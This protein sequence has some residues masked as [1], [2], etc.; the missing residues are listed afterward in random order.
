VDGYTTT[1]RLPYAQPTSRLGNYIRNSVKAAVDA[2]D[3]SIVLYV[4]DPKDPLIQAYQRIFPTLLK[5]LAQMPSDLRSHVRYPQDLF[6]I[7]AHVFAT[8]HMESPRVFYNKEDLW[9]IPKKGEKDMEPYYTI[10]KLPKT[11]GATEAPKEEFILLIP[12]T[13]AKRDNMAAWLAA[14][15]D[16]SHYG[17][18]IVYLF[19]K[20]KLVYGPR[21]VDARIDQDSAISQ[22]IT[23]WSQRGSQVI[24]G[25]LLAIPI[26]DALLYIQPLYLSASEGALPE[27]RRVIVA[28]GNHLSMDTNLEAALE[29]IFGRAATPSARPAAVAAGPTTTRTPAPAEARAAPSARAREALDHFTKAQAALKE[30]DWA[31]YGEELKKMRMILEE[32]AKK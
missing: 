17:K 19:P 5:P 12:F 28:Y 4:S 18:L 2:Y 13:P 24:R 32:L 11:G 14:R 10:M 1:D 30:Q 7:Q 31:R 16:G 20:Q 8:Y 26:E 29:G 21:Q 15:S 9:S 22:Q 23:L 27:L 25:S 3:G 6:N